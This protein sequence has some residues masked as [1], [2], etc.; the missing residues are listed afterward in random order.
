M[1]DRQKAPE[2]NA[3]YDMSVKKPE[4]RRM[5]NG[6]ALNIIEAGTQ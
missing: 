4:R 1:L 2:I 6:M 5:K 3:M